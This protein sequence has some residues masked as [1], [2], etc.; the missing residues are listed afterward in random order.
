MSSRFP[1]DAGVQVISYL[2]SLELETVR[3]IVG[4]IE[5]NR[6]PKVKALTL[7]DKDKYQRKG[8]T[9]KENSWSEDETFI[10][11]TVLFSLDGRDK[12]WALAL[13]RVKSHNGM[14]LTLRSGKYLLKYIS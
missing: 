3:C 6:S 11:A 10:F 12:P 13:K 8:K 9:S 1:K 4:L 7:K 14:S 5:Q 2:K